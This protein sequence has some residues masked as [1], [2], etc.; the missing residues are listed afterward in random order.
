MF[1][2]LVL[3]S[4]NEVSGN[5]SDGAGNVSL[6]PVGEVYG[7]APPAF[8]HSRKVHSFDQ[9]YNLDATDPNRP[10]LNIA[11]TN[12]VTDVTSSGLGIDNVGIRATSDAASANFVLTDFPKFALGILGLSVS[13][14]L[15]H[16][17]SDAS[18]V[19][20]PDRGFLGGEA[21]FG[22]L[23]I[24]GALIGKTLSFSGT[25]AADTILFHSPTVT[26]TLDK[27]TLSGFYPPGPIQPGGPMIPASVA[28]PVGPPL[29]IPP[30]AIAPNQITTDAIDIQFTNASVFGRTFSGEI[31]LG[32]TSAS[33]FPPLHAG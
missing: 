24:G 6:G 20:G 17:E 3:G 7:T 19:F 30:I 10:T 28:L 32:V 2:Q 5:L 12:V 8:N 18:Y 13:A 14:T 21:S 16:S 27:Q 26:V 4:A 22:S 15:V 29:P 25:A 31:T 11:A 33:L 9:A 1:S 23:V